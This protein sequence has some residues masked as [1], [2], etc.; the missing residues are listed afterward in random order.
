[1][2][3]SYELITVLK[4]GLG[5]DGYKKF[6]ETMIGWIEKTGGE[7]IHIKPWGLRE[8]A[9][10][11]KKQ[12]QGYYI[13]THFKGKKETLGEIDS[14]LYVDEN[15]IRK[16]LVTLDSVN[17]EL[18]GVVEISHEPRQEK[19]RRAPRKERSPQEKVS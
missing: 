18:K 14:R 8:L 6:Q 16:L 11:F 19:P 12:T 4:P 10:I 17:P 7:I 5:E 15:V 13:Q 3:K 2:N 1:M 9:T